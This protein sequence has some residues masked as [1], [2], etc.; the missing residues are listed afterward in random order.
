MSFRTAVSPAVLALLMHGASPAAEHVPWQGDAASGGAPQAAAPAQ[1][2]VLR[3]D[4]G[5]GRMRQRLNMVLDRIELRPI[6]QMQTRQVRVELGRDLLAEPAPGRFHCRVAGPPARASLEAALSAAA[7]RGI[8]AYAL[9]SSHD[10]G[11]GPLTVLTDELALQVDPEV[12][13]QAFAGEFGMRWCGCHGQRAVQVFALP[14]GKGLAQL[15]LLQ[16]LAADCR[17]RSAQVLRERDARPRLVPNDPLLEDQWHL[18][19]EHDINVEPVWNDYRGDGIHIA[20]VDTGMDVAHEDLVANALPGW[21]YLDDDADPRP[22]DLDEELHATWVA[23]TAAAVGDNGIGVAGV[24]YEA[25]IVPLR[26]ISGNF[27][28]ADENGAFTHGLG[29]G[30][31]PVHVSN[32]SWGPIDDARRIEAPGPLA[33]AGFEDG[34]ESGRGGLGIIYLFAGGNGREGTGGDV[35]DYDGYVGSRFTIGVASVHSASAQ[36][37]YSENGNNLLVSAPGGDFVFGGAYQEGAVQTTDLTGLPGQSPTNY[38]QTNDEVVGT[39]FACPVAAGVCALVL[40]ANAALSWRDMQHVLAN[41][42]DRIDAGDATWIQNA[43]GKWFSRRYG[44]GRVDAEGAVAAALTWNHV[45]PLWDEDPAP[46]LNAYEPLSVMSTTLNRQLTEYNELPSSFTIDMDDV[47]PGFY[48]EHVELYVDI[49]HASRG[50]MSYVLESPSGTVHT[51]EDRAETDFNDDIDW[52]FL[53]NGFWGEEP[54]GGWKLTIVDPYQGNRGTIHSFGLTFHGYVLTESVL[55]LVSAASTCNA[56]ARVGL[57]GDTLTVI[58]TGFMA[59]DNGPPA[60]AGSRVTWNGQ[61]LA[62]T[63]VSSTELRATVPA[64]LLAVLG[65]VQIGVLSPSFDGHGGASNTLPFTVVPSQLRII[66]DAAVQAVLG[67]NFSH[68]CVASTAL[69]ASGGTASWNLLSTEPAGLPVALAGNGVL[70][71]T[72][73]AS[74]GGVNH[75]AVTVQASAGGATDQQRLVIALAPPTAVTQLGN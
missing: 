20:V 57:S 11:G 66:S 49:T 3:I 6:G 71:W 5:E 7:A 44:F 63:F 54:E 22:D 47:P 9:T 18:I 4:I 72:G 30:E 35:A 19:S 55:T 10:D 64:A 70:T 21:D 8:P 24:A 31:T 29:V 45:P 41:T 23:G 26:L 43:A 75:V 60:F 40:D 74:P 52:T 15:D 1:V 56:V 36:A 51:I 42:S 38:V 61:V 2:P 16:R 50:Q 37:S 62:T 69:L 17:V 73:V 67:Q 48:L 28:D 14:A 65:T 34:I 68:T 59:P 25:G 32:N 53:L 58:G 33:E 27:S 13:A 39:S 12:D 46:G